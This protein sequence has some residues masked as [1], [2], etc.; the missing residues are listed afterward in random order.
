MASW[1]IVISALFFPVQGY[2][3][4]IYFT[5]RCGGKTFVTFL[6]DSVF[7][8]VCSV[9]VALV[10]CIFTELPILPI[11]AVVQALDLIKIAIGYGMIRKG[12]WIANL[13]EK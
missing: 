4:A 9:P 3:N 8:W 1:F 13:V 2:L 10:L 5:L 7:S 6:F 12:V 11:Y